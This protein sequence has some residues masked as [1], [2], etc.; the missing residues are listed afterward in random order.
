MTQATIMLADAR[1]ADA[2]R[3]DQGLVAPRAAELDGRAAQLF[4][5]PRSGLD[6]AA[7][8]QHGEPVAADAGDQRAFA[9]APAHLRGDALNDL[10][11]D[12]HAMIFI[13]DVQLID[14]DVE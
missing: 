8:Q 11:A 12:V 9:P 14:I 13:D 3:H 1:H 2:E 7:R 5:D 10:V 6:A 4:G